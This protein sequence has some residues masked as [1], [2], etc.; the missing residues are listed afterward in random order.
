[1]RRRN[2]DWLPQ[3]QALCRS[4]GVEISAW[5][6]ETLVVF[7]ASPEDRKIIASQFSPLGFQPMEDEDDAQAGLLTLSRN[8]EAALVALDSID[9]SRRGLNELLVP[10]IW[11]AFSAGFI[12]VSIA[13]RRHSPIAPVVG[14]ALLMLFFWDATRI[15]G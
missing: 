10:L 1:M 11:G 7:A 8:V 13:G 15:W 6:E 12:Y 14:L 2:P 3:A 4:L 5:G 9:I